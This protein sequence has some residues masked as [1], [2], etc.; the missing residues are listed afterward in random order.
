MFSAWAI[1]VAGAAGLFGL[2]R[3]GR[4]A[5]VV[6]LA[7]AGYVVWLTLVLCAEA[8]ALRLPPIEPF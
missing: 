7:M 5:R 4:S 2:V 3:R 1:A 8:M 6:A